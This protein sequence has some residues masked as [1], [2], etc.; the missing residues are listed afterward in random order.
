[1]PTAPGHLHRSGLPGFGSALAPRREGRVDLK[2]ESEEVDNPYFSSGSGKIDVDGGAGQAGEIAFDQL[3]LGPRA[4]GGGGGGG[5][6]DGP[7][8]RR[9]PAGDGGDIGVMVY[10]R[11]PRLR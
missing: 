1:M 6:D 9:Q 8:A 11:T 5:W 2:D 4:R 3:S 10:S 7:Q